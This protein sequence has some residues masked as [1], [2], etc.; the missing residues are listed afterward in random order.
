M[1]YRRKPT[2]THWRFAWPDRP[3]LV[4]PFPTFTLETL[5]LLLQEVASWQPAGDES[6]VVRV[7]LVGWHWRTSARYPRLLVETRWW[8]ACIALEQWPLV[9]G[10]AKGIRS[11]RRCS[12]VRGWHARSPFVVTV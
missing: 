11:R 2:G 10:L 1:A 3:L 12:R 5:Q 8:R 4:P 9:T 6:A 7:E